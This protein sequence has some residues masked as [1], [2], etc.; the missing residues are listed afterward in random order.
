MRIIVIVVGICFT[1]L[2]YLQLSY[3]EEILE[4]RREQF[5]ESV[6]RSINRVIYT[7]ELDETQRGLLNDAKKYLKTEEKTTPEDTAVSKKA[8]DKQ[9]KSHL[10]PPII[11]DSTLSGPQL[12][13]MPGMKIPKFSKDN[14]SRPHNHDRYD[15][16]NAGHNKEAL[17][18]PA[19]ETR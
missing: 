14:P 18:I 9:F 15:Q 13:M 1:I 11:N 2:L 3:L 4:M 12:R 5:T 17:C 8:S 6:N 16:G 19:K 10:Y 7:I